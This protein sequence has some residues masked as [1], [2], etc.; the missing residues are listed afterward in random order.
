MHL[1]PGDTRRLGDNWNERQGD[2]EIVPVGAVLN[3]ATYPVLKLAPSQGVVSHMT[4][5]K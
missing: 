5:V 4:T 3:G 1:M 2:V